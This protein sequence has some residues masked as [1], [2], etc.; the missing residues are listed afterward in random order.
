MGGNNQA[1]AKYGTGYCDAQCPHDIKFIDGEANTIDWKPN[2][3]DKSNNMGAGKYGTCCAEMDIWEANSMATA[4][5]PHPCEMDAEPGQLRCE[6][7]QCGDNDKGERYQGVCDKDGCDI[8]PFRMGNES[9]YGRGPGFV[10]DTSKPMTQV[11]QFLTTDG[12]DDGDLSEIRR[13]YVQEGRIIH[14]PPSKILGPKNSDSITDEFCA[15]KKELFDDVN[16]FGA[17]GG[18]RQMGRSLDRGQ[19]LALSLWDDVEVNMLWL[20]SVYPLD[21]PA[22]SPGVRRGTCPG[23]V[24]STPTYV[25]NNFPDGYVLFANAAIGEIGSTLIGSTGPF[26]TTPPPPCVEQCSSRPGQNTPECNGKTRDRC[27]FM[28][29][30]ENKCQ[31]TECQSTTSSTTGSPVTTPES[32]TPTTTTLSCTWGAQII[33]CVSQGGDFHCEQCTDGATNEPC[34]SC[35]GGEPPSTSTTT[36][37]SPSTT[38]AGGVCKVWCGDNPKPWKKKCNWKG[39]SG[40]SECNSRR[41]HAAVFLL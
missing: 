38:T 2:P 29:Q 5:T 16:D 26:P 32:T 35:Q 18:N 23:G 39:C 4:Y 3:K 14:S 15:A 31:W 33:A 41:L 8:N 21:K 1:G 27:R 24:S 17:K 10:V 11:T 40:C 7:R 25:R 34:C 37:T 6:G 13:F 12:T 9:F 22:V 20:D 30:Y 36:V 28:A 19:V